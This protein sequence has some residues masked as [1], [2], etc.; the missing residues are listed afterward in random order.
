[1]RRR[2]W[3]RS[4]ARCV[5]ALT[6]VTVLHHTEQGGLG[7]SSPLYALLPG[8]LR[9]LDALSTSL[10]SPPA[11]STTSASIEPILLP[12]LPTLLLLECVLVYLPPPDT[13]TILRWFASNFAPGS[14]VVSYDPFGL[15]DSFGKV[16]RRNLAV[17]V[18]VSLMS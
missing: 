16:M 8:D 4:H 18:P 12:S 5:R 17:S 9:H 3:L 6:L 13:D 11:Y 10:L 2:S 1:M 15:D 7:L 14:A